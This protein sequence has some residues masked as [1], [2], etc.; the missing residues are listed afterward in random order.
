MNVIDIE[1]IFFLRDIFL[2]EKGEIKVFLNRK[3]KNAQYEK[4]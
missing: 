4:S 2:G 3:A 1:L